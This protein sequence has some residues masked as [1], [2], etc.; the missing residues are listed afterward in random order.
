[1][2]ITRINRYLQTVFPALLIII[3]PFIG[4]LLYSIFIDLETSINIY[5]PEFIAVVILCILYFIFGHFSRI[6]IKK[7]NT[8]I[9]YRLLLYFL[10]VEDELNTLLKRGAIPLFLISLIFSFIEMF[11][12]HSTDLYEKFLRLAMALF[13]SS[14][15]IL[16][17]IFE[18]M[19]SYIFKELYQKINISHAIRNEICYLISHLEK[20]NSVHAKVRKAEIKDDDF[21]LYVDELGRSIKALTDY[22]KDWITY[23]TALPYKIDVYRVFRDMLVRAIFLGESNDVINDLRSLEDAI[24]QK[25]QNH[26]FKIISI[27]A[28]KNEKLLI[29]RGMY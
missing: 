11:F 17:I 16:Y 18:P 28:S 4:V 9:Q 24:K 27:I 20:L 21:E 5:N 12:I 3:I 15:I 29:C 14:G 8:V 25:S 13:F 1:M 2:Q 19:I 22:L 23:Y 26:V 10:N 7:E 6:F